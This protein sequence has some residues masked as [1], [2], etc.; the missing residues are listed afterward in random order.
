MPVV[1]NLNG[2]VLLELSGERIM[3]SQGQTIGL[4]DGNKLCSL[5]GQ[6]LAEVRGGSVF[7]VR[8]AASAGGVMFQR[9]KVRDGSVFRVGLSPGALL[10]VEGTKVINLSGQHIATVD[11]GSEEERALLAAAFLLMC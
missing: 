6:V 1:K 11:S 3:N 9:E 7:R 2:Q 5:G 10:S 4:T 8:P